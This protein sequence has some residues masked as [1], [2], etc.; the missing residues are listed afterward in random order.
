MCSVSRHGPL[1]CSASALREAN[2]TS[3][4]LSNTASES[5]EL[6]VWTR[7][8]YIHSLWAWLSAPTH[9]NMVVHVT[10][11]QLVHRVVVFPDYSTILLTTRYLRSASSRATLSMLVRMCDG[12]LSASHAIGARIERQCRPCVHN[13]CHACK[14]P[15]T[16]LTR[17]VPQ[18]LAA[19]S[20]C[21]ARAKPSER[22]G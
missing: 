14:L 8:Q 10:R 17:H 5:A 16:L 13:G 21:R 18:I 9:H 22:V 12:L 20:V 7:R 2:L 6:P 15:I 19:R 3:S 1:Q 4:E 11:V